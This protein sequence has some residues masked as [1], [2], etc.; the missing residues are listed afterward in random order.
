MAT[1]RSFTSPFQLE[2]HTQALLNI[3]NMYGMIQNM[4]L[5]ETEGVTQHL[6]SFEEID[7]SIGLVGDRPRGERNNVSRDDLR[8][9]RAYPVPHF[10]LDDAIKPEDIQ[11]N[12]AYG[13]AAEGRPERVELV[14]MRKLERIRRSHAQTLEYARIRTITDGTI[15][16]PNGTVA[17]NFYTDFGVTRKNVNFAL[18][19]QTTEVVLKN[20]EVIAHIQDNIG[21]G[22]LVTE[23]V[24]L[25]SPTFFDK[26]IT[27]AGVKE[28]YKY[29]SSV[30]EPLRNR[31][32]NG[33]NRE[34]V[35]GGI[36]YI[37]YRGVMFGNKILADDKAYAIPMGTEG[38][39]KTFFSP[40]N[41]FDFVNTV[42]EEAYVFERM[43]D[44]GTEILL[45]SE[46]N[47]INLIT[48]PQVIVEMS[49]V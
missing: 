6:V 46:S 42:G 36:R 4:G 47:F 28:A 37:E 3:P 26:L 31:L 23:V 24:A 14:R 13:G 40:A 21:D 25:C 38:I 2:D 12:S 10:P 30:Q 20:E 5:F 15:F 44:S 41:R 18:T 27:Q 45:E 8:R 1:I 22:S 48:R 11:G 29:Y 33:M 32:G 7:Q 17:G 34:F 43:N 16:A 49:A 39:F 35:H 9:I 19:T